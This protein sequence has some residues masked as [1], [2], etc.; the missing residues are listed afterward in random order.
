MFSK[1]NVFLRIFKICSTMT[2]QILGLDIGTN[3]IG[4]AVVRGQGD[5]AQP[6]QEIVAAGSRVIPVDAGVLGDFE[7]GVSSKSKAA[8]RT[9]FRQVRRMI[10]RSHLRRQRLLR[11]LQV[12]DYLPPHYARCLDR[13]GKF[14]PHTEPKIAWSETADGHYEF[15]F[16][17]AFDEMMV[18]FRQRNPEWVARGGKVP[19]DWTL[20]YLRTKAL[21][22][23]VDPYEL[24]WILL[25]FNQKRGYRQARGE[26]QEDDSRKLEE[27]KSL[28][29]LSV[30]DTGEKKGDQ[31]WYRVLLEDGS[32]Y[33]RLSRN[34][35]PWEGQVRDFIVT[36]TLDAQGNPKTEKDGRVKRTYRSPKADDWT[37]LKKKTEAQIAQAHQ[38]VGAYIF[39]ALLHNPS[40]KIRGKLVH[41][42]DRKLYYDELKAILQAQQPYHAALTDSA[43]LER[44]VRTLYQ[45]NEAHARQ[46]LCHDLT[47]FLLDDVLFYQRPLKSQ[48]ALIA[49][50]SFESL[51]Y[52]DRQTGEEK[53]APVKCIPKSHP[54]YAEY[55]LW[56]FLDNLRIYQLEG[57][58]DGKK[59]FDIDVT[60]QFLPDHEAYARL[61]DWLYHR[62]NVSWK[63]L[64]KYPPFG[65][66]RTTADLYRW[67]YAQDKSYPCHETWAHMQ[68]CLKKAKL[69]PDF[70]TPEREE[71]LW[72]ILYSVS[73]MQELG[74][75]LHTFAHKNGLTDDEAERFAKFFGKMEPFAH[76]Y[77][78]CSAKALK[79]LLPLMR[80]GSY[81]SEEALA[82]GVRERIGQL[83]AGTDD[84]ALP[85][86]AREALKALHA[87][88]DYQGLPLWLASYVVYNRH[89]EA[90]DIVRWETP[91]DIDRFLLNFRPNELRNPIVE[92]VVRE[93]LRVVRDIWTRYGSFDEIHVELGREMKMPAQQRQKLSERM[94]ENER[95][96]LR[97]KMMLACFQHPEFEVDDVRPYSPYQQE[98]LKIYEEYVLRDVKDI[99]DDI[100]AILRKFGESTAAKQPSAKEVLRYRLWLDQKYTSPYTGQIIPL[101]RLFTRDYEIEH[102]IPQK[103]YFDDS[104]SNKVICESAVNKLKSAQLA[105]EFISQHHGEVVEL[106][107]G[108]TARILELE[109]YERLVKD[110]YSHVRL[111]HKR[112]NLL[113]D[114]VPEAFIAR[115]LNDTRYISKYVSMLLSN[116]VRGEDERSVNSTHL[117]ATNGSI[118]T[119]L[120]QDWGINDV[121]NAI[122][123]PRFERLNGM[124]QTGDHMENVYVKLNTQGHLIP[125][126]PLDRQRG[127][128][129]KRIDHRHHA[130]DAIV[131]AC[132]SRNMVNYL[133]NE[134]AR[135]GAKVTRM[136]LQH[137]L[138]TKT[139]ADANGNYRW[140]MNKP[141]PTFT[142]DVR[143]ALEDIVASFKQNRR[144]MSPTVNYFDHYDPATGKKRRKKQTQ[145]E[146]QA[147]RKPLHKATLYGEINLRSIKEVSLKQALEQPQRMVNKDL[148]HKLQTLQAEGLN[149]KQMTAYFAE[150]HDEWADVNVKKIPIYVY[151]KEE[152][153][154]RYFA[155]R[156]ALDKSFTRETIERKVADTGIQQILLRHLAHYENAEQAFSPEGIEEMNRHLTELNGGKPHQPIYK[157]RKYEQADK[158][159][160]GQRNCKAAQF[161]E[162]E[163]GTNLYFAVYEAESEPHK[164]SFATIPLREAVLRLKKGLP[165]ALE[166][167]MAGEK[168]KFVLS[169]LD[170]VYVPTP[171]DLARG[172]VQLPLDKKRIYKMVS[173]SGNQCFFVLANVASAIVDK[174]EFS[175]LNKMERAV[176]GEMIKEICLPLDV[177]RLGNVHLRQ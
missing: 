172:Q 132:A 109:D 37:L 25:S 51:T 158:Y 11:V 30:E 160:V 147:V 17:D 150:H 73:D 107:N 102:I 114:E 16:R 75:A 159:P 53:Q 31:T 108:R 1:K 174:Y 65:L 176:T 142:T 59:C 92:L 39:E 84:A 153:K 70:L 50:C 32:E 105:H 163:K 85:A 166:T 78:A 124:V 113:Q 129:M 118:T 155:S 96:N 151:S 43:V 103:R 156:C 24:A 82:P 90:K 128:S 130:M 131:I 120:K 149:L 35:L 60:R 64:P 55:R 76:D 21:S 135:K 4:W 9:A 148:R 83:L 15:L 36:T 133:N 63:D 168:L 162:A 106:G 117:I 10:E 126:V 112:R 44:C 169:P 67:N 137:L 167:N 152:G 144:I 157:V 93:T 41:T 138:C 123:M 165:V 34:P 46:A 99:P 62:E 115:Q 143:H 164:R 145:G 127:F 29:V 97:I 122:V 116:I 2:K 54:L 72:H 18:A 119:R 146:M 94:L 33:K 161:V 23:P 42:I 111:S 173:S 71:A 121:W 86:K 40:Q 52:Y 100:A 87:V 154:A 22:Q 61:F 89:A 171:E 77:G 38:T 5:D 88:S 134:S 19:Y 170:L 68:Q 104:L 69:S 20:Y 177:D 141:W 47:A 7:R 139:R 136:D 12:M 74:R 56:Q 79:K 125:N 110:N 57:E 3:S 58:V 13:Y 48:K 8:E 27:Y 28:K 95:T 81:W 98:I 91:A 101:G 66:T 26:Q 49:N 80:R 45:K 14:L 175:S 140:V 6:L